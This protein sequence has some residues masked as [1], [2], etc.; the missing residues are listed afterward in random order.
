MTRT[1]EPPS[2]ATPPTSR[3]RPATQLPAS[4]PSPQRRRLPTLVPDNIARD[5]ATLPP[6]RRPTNSWLYMPLILD[7]V[8][9]PLDIRPHAH[10]FP[11]TPTF[12]RHVRDLRAVFARQDDPITLAT[13]RTTYRLDAQAH[14]DAHHQEHLLGLDEALG[15]RIVMDG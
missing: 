15:Q 2:S 9:M 13:I 10:A 1:R 8:R 5:H 11:R 4:C 3:R 6:H 7:A 12:T 14:I